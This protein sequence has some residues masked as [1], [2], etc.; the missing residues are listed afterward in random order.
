MRGLAPETQEAIIQQEFEKIAPVRRVNYIAGT[1]EAVVIFENTAVGVGRFFSTSAPDLMPFN[2]RLQDVGKVLMQRDSITVDGKSVG[3]AG[4]G[5]GS[6][7]HV[8]GAAGS[9]VPLMPRQATRSRGRVGLAGARG[10][11]GGRGRGGL[12]FV[13]STRPTAEASARKDEG[14]DSKMDAPEASASKK[15]QDDFR[16]MLS[17]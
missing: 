12:G 15:S 8:S 2:V 11:R 5:Q 9:D 14:G 7:K 4:E 17:K 6:R 3:I 16:A 1:T 10:G 13:A